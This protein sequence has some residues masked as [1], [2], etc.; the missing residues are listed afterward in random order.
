MVIILISQ[1]WIKLLFDAYS[2][3]E[4]YKILNVRKK[5][6]IEEID[7][8]ISVADQQ[9]LEMLLRNSLHRLRENNEN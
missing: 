1:E 4:L 3:I 5:K 2:L 9:L 7:Y 8:E 6:R